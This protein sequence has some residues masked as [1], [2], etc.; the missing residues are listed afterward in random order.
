[1][2]VMPY[3]A[4]L[5]AQACE[6]TGHRVAVLD[7]MFSSDPAGLLKKELKRI[8]PDVVGLSIRNIDNNNLMNPEVY[9]GELLGLVNTIKIYS[10]AIIVLGG[11][12]IGIMPE[13]FLRFT[14][15]SLAVTGYGEIVFPLLLKAISQKTSLDIKGV[16]RR[17]N[18]V[19]K[20][21]GT[22]DITMGKTYNVPDFNKWINTR[23]Y[24]RQLSSMP[25]QTKRGCPFECIYCTYPLIEGR[26]YQLIEADSVIEAIKNLVE[27]GFDD[28]EFVDN[29]FNSPYEQALEICIK[30]KDEKIKAR[31]QA[32]SL[33]PKYVDDKLLQVMQNAGFSGIGI[34]A[35]S[36]SDK[37][38]ANLGKNYNLNEL[39]SAA[40]V[41]QKYKIPCFW[42]F[43]LGGPGETKQTVEET[44]DFA[45]YYIRPRDVVFFNIGIRIYPET[46]LENKAEEEGIKNKEANLLKPLYYISK[47]LDSRWIVSRVKKKIKDNFNFIDS[48]TMETN[49]LPA[50]S[51][52][53]YLF[54]M[55]PPLWKNTAIIRHMAR[56][57][58]MNI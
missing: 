12:A 36:A 16:A 57:M 29:V 2:I 10:G 28:I 24:K 21:V 13:E 35:E 26:K 7:L 40:L 44:M 47:D 33:H 8:K 32:L 38:L 37:V 18:G 6:E 56:D 45:R 50:V 17:E 20:R 22:N 25:V 5:V 46:I 48:N 43:M 34:T 55:K 39:R 4:C 9:H 41:V 49:F 19:F 3:G 27:K 1:M 23:S 42:M 51:N 14:G 31:F 54:G 30:I 58:G 15:L 11:A 53:S 52:L